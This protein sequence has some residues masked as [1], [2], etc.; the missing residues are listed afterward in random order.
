MLLMRSCVR[1][2]LA[3]G[4]LLATVGCGDDDKQTGGFTGFATNPLPT[5]PTMPTTPTTPGTTPGTDESSDSSSES[6]SSTMPVDPSTGVE[7]PTTTTT[8]PPTSSPT[9]EPPDTTESTSSTTDDTSTST[10]TTMGTSTTTTMGTSTTTTMGMTT[11]TTM[12]MTTNEPPA[13]D[14]QPAS[15]LYSNCFPS[16]MCPG[17]ANGGCLSLQDANMVTFDGF[18]TIL[19]NSPADCTPKPNSQ[20][21]SQCLFINDTQKTCFLACGTDADCPTG[22]TCELVA[23]PQGDGSYC[24]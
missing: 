13:K 9:T 17:L 24:W 21:V 8:A 4:L 1:G 14:P 11:T 16:E 5:M 12:G 23:L 10:T 20:A 7:E 22:M 19:C 15:G 3:G 18:C 2:L 6:E